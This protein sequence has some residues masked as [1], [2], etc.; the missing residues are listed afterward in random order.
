MLY[1]RCS[2]GDYTIIEKG[3]KRISP[4][5]MEGLLERFEYQNSLILSK[6]SEKRSDEQE[7]LRSIGAFGNRLER[8]SLCCI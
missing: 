1:R 3:V 6:I 7:V 8:F 4:K 5:Q 2:S